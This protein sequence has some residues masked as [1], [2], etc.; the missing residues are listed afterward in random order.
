MDPFRTKH[1]LGVSRGSD[2]RISSQNRARSYDESSR[3]NSARSAAEGNSVS[4]GM[5]KTDQVVLEC[6]YKITEIIVQSRV[7]FQP[8]GDGRSKRARVCM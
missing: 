7:T 4:D 5:L 3:S 6:I 1:A 2:G 8:D